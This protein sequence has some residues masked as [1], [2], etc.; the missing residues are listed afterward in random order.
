MKLTVFSLICLFVIFAFAGVQPMAGYKDNFLAGWSNTFNSI[1]GQLDIPNDIPPTVSVDS[2]KLDDT[3][4]VDAVPVTP[5]PDT[6]PPVVTF[7][8]KVVQDDKIEHST[9]EYKDFFL[10]LVYDSSGVVLSGNGCYD[11]S[12]DF[13]VL[14][15][16]LA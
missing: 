15:K 6:E 4:R 5:L 3:Q 13:I 7:K 9:G 11:N 14:I 2:A 8:H 12:G 1:D 10:G 16:I